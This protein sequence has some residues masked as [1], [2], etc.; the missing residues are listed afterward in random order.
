MTRPHVGG[1]PT[2][3]EAQGDP[4]I[5]AKARA[6]RAQGLG[7]EKVALMLR[8]SKRTAIRRARAGSDGGCKTRPEGFGTVVRPGAPAPAQQEEGRP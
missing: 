5:G 8:I 3:E 6:L 7:W 2:A 4:E 1:R